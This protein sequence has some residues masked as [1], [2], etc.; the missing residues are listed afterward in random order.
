MAMA[1]NNHSLSMVISNYLINN[2]IIKEYMTYDL[3]KDA[4]LFIHPNKV[5]EFLL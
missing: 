5:V 4:V 2:I 1:D 3:S